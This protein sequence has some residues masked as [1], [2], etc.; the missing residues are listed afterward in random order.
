M[1]KRRRSDRNDNHIVTDGLAAGQACAPG[2]SLSVQ[3]LTA[4]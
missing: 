1:C 3:A 4:F 2:R